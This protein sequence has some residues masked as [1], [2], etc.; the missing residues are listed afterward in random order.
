VFFVPTF[1]MSDD[2]L[3]FRAVTQWLRACVACQIDLPSLLSREGLEGKLNDPTAA[4]IERAQLERIMQCCIEQAWQ[5]SPSRYFPV[6]LAKSARFEYL[7]D[8]DAFLS[9]APSLRDM[10]PLLDVLPAFFDPALRLTVSEFGAEARVVMRQIQPGE[11]IEASKPF[12]E[13]FFLSTALACHKWLNDPNANVRVTFRHQRHAGSDELAA[14]FPVPIHF[15]YGQEL[16]ACWFDRSLLDRPLRGA[17]PSLHQA[18][19]GRIAK[20][21]AD[22]TPPPAAVGTARLT[23][24]LESLIGEKTELLQLSQQDVAQQLG[25]HP[26]ALQRRLKAEG[27]TYAE[28][29]NRVR[30]T[31]AKKWL[32][33]SNESVEEIARKLGYLD[34]TGFTQAFVRW[35]GIAP[36]K[37]RHQKLS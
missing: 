23:T 2:S 10:L 37:Y 31:L 25:L 21:L 18:A 26:R 35:A 33:T 36:A 30:F 5:R 17:L 19:A 32:L 1:T 12:V 8:L 22:P 9:T 28:V 13:Q 14:A 20:Q 27:G 4:V 24:Q 34:R 6:V 3:N 29:L 7:S 15:T 16:D 11:T